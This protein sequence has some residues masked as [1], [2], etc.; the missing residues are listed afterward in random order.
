MLA[1]AETSPDKIALA[2]LGPA[3]AERWSYAR[4]NDA[5]EQAAGG[6]SAAG[7]RPGDRVLLRLGNSATFPVAF[8]G[9]IRAGIVPVPTSSALTASEVTRL[10]QALPPHAILADDGVALPDP[11]KCPVFGPGILTGMPMAARETN[12]DDLAYIVFTS[13]S[14]GV[15]KP[16]AHAHRAVWARRMMWDGW[17]GL[18]A[19]D[20][21]MHTGA[22]NWTYTLG[23][24][25]LDPWAIGATALVPASGTDPAT[26][27]LLAKRHDASILAGSPGIFRKLLHGA[28]APMPKLRHALSAGESLPPSLRA[29]WREATGTDI[30]EALGMSEI[31]TFLSGSPARPAP[32]GT[33]G[34]A[35]VG[36]RLRIGANG[37]LAIHHSDPGLMLGYMK[38][39]T[40]HLPLT[41]GWFVTSDRVEQRA[42][43]AFIYHGREDDMLTA[44][45]YRIA[46]AEIE[47]AFDGA[48]G[49]TDCAALALRPNR[50]TTLL[51]LAYCGTATDTALTNIAASTLAAYKRPRAYIQL[52]ALPRS[53]NGKLDRGALTRAVKDMT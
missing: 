4:L 42:D 16:V 36:R 19:D 53:A 9:A 10:V 47:A 27:A 12:P 39:G 11:V 20:R 23:T 26:L 30:H 35:Q 44:G 14:S 38:D 22:M 43:G 37:L 8:L 29:R 25:L 13:G 33:T 52:T 34:F 46:P 18:R 50:E 2:V 45:G 41:D 17:Y 21:V 5:V 51:A 1:H 28:L 32:E 31:S 15:P 48:D 24:G 49:L 6:L 40:P 7:L 3:R